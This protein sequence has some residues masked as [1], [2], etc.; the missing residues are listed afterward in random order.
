MI[1]IGTGAQAKY[2]V[3]ICS[4]HDIPIEKVYEPYDRSWKNQL[5]LNRYKVESFDYGKLK[6]YCHLALCFSNQYEKERYFQKLQTLFPIFA[7]F[8]HPTATIGVGAQIG[9][10]TIIN[11]NAVIQP[12]AK[13]GNFC[14]IHSG[15]TVDHNCD[16]SDF[17][18]LAPGVT[19][20]GGISIG[21]Y[22]IINTGTIVVPNVHIGEKTVIGAGSLIL[23]N[24]GSNQTIF[25][26]PAT[27]S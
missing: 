7:T 10:G 25:G 1:I 18:N 3:D 17:V 16:I 23:K 8:V 6:Q 21:K 13:I 19:L 4:R 2:V 24:V 5:F 11:A 22:T 12:E 15:V 26:H 14:M 27:L 9:Q 20:A